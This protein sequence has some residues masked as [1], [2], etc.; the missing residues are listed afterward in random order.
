MAAKNVSY[1]VFDNTSRSP[2]GQVKMAGINSNSPGVPTRRVFGFYALVYVTSGKGYFRD[3][4]GFASQLQPGDLLIL[5]PEIGHS[6][7]PLEHECWDETFVVFEGEVFDLWRRQGLLEPEQPLHHLG[8]V[9][10]WHK[11]ITSA[12][13]THP[14]SGP[15]FALERL[16]R[17]QQLLADI[18]LQE[19]QLSDEKTAWFSQATALLETRV[20]TPPQYAELAANL[21]MSYESFRK[22]FTKEAGMSPGQYFIQVRMK[23]ACELLVSRDVTIKEA[24][25]ELGF[26]DEFHFSKQF[27]KVM[28]MTPTDFCRLFR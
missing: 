13:W 27:K 8:P 16:C 22:R 9:E 26:F 1:I 17:F 7:G 3:D 10:H 28:G 18:L 12:V 19:H 23:R 4:N 6:Y 15:H 25:I 11:R 2:L 5:F 24:S 21:D 14:K 20:D